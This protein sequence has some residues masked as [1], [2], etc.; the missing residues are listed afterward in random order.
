MITRKNSQLLALFFKSAEK[1]LYFHFHSH[2][3]VI[4]SIFFYQ[5]SNLYCNQKVFSRVC[6]TF[7]ELKEKCYE[8]KC[9][10]HKITTVK[11]SKKLAIKKLLLIGVILL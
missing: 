4:C 1:S 5:V 6:S 3:L 9:R 10:A 11:C 8:Y 2:V 7:I